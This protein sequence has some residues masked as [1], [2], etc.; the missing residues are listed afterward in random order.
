MTK[1]ELKK[2]ERKYSKLKKKTKEKIRR[3]DKENK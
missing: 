2:L 3:Q 1:K